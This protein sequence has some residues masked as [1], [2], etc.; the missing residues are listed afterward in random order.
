MTQ[1]EQQTR[2]PV[3]GAGRRRAERAAA[4]VAA[5]AAATA[6]AAP[7]ASPA[8][9]DGSVTVR[10]VRAVDESGTWS[11]ALEPGLAGV[12]VTLTGEDGGVRTGVTAADGTVT[13]KPAKDTASGKY[14]VEVV[15]P[16]PGVLYPAFAAR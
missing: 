4:V 7:S 2:A 1:T 10:V 6:V 14:R 16:Q 3:R 9:A 13:L 11:P 12:T 15:N 8:S 5:F